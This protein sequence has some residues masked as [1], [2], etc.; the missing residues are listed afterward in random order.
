MSGL[1]ACAQCM[2]PHTAAFGL[3]WKNMWYMPFQKIGPLGS[4]IQFFAGRRWNCGRRGS[5]AR[6]RCR[7][8]LLKNANEWKSFEAGTVARGAASSLLT[9]SRREANIPT[10]VPKKRLAEFGHRGAKTAHNAFLSE[11]DHGV[12][13]RRRDGLSNDGDANRVDEQAGL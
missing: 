4:F 13:K 8:S 3:Y 11:H 2:S 10:S 6:R 12:K 7:S 5:A 1:T 9:N